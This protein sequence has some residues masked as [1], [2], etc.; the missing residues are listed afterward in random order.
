MQYLRPVNRVTARRLLVSLTFGL[1]AVIA[2]LCSGDQIATAATAISPYHRFETLSPSGP[3]HRGAD[4]AGVVVVRQG[5]APNSPTT[6]SDPC[7][8]A[9]S[10][11]EDATEA[12]ADEAASDDACPVG[13]PPQSFSPTTRVELASGTFVPIS[14]IKVG[15]KVLATDPTSGKT[16]AETVTA[17]DIHDDTDLVDLVVHTAGGDRTIHT[18]DL[19][20]VWDVTTVTT[21]NGSSV[22]HTTDHHLIFDLRTHRWTEAKDLRRGDHVRT[23]DGSIA[24]VTSTTTV[25]GSADMWDLTV[26]S[27]HDFYVVVTGGTGVLVHNVDGPGCAD[28]VPGAASPSLKDLANEV[29]TAGVHP[30][31]INQRT[32]AVG[33]DSDETLFAGSSNGFDAGQRA[34]LERLGIQR[35][36]GSANLHA[37]EELLRGVPNLERVGTSVRAPCGPDEN[38]CASKLARAGVEVDS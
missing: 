1:A 25:A 22:I 8:A 12:P 15:D 20:P 4:R 30:A 36:P 14:S 10:G 31:A 16:T 24:T 33:I 11:A 29:R 3:I 21:A 17:T 34:A 38:D 9:E 23:Q 7:N 5:S 35:V 37:E 32:I 19:H 6:A 27:V 26:N 18:T 28:G 13:A 2:I